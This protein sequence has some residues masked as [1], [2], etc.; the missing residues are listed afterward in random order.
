MTFVL[1]I[2]LARGGSKSIPLKNLVKVH[3]KPLLEYTFDVAKNSGVLN[4]YIVST[5]SELIADF[6]KHAGVS[7]PFIRPR[8]LAD[9]TASS[10][11]ALRHAVIEY[12]EHTGKRVTHIAELMATNPMKT[13]ADLNKM[14]TKLLVEGLPSIIAVHRIF[15]QHPC[16]LKLIDE[17]G[18]LSDFF[19]EPPEAR[20]QALLPQVFIRSGAIYAMTREFLFETSG[21][22]MS[23]ISKAYLLAEAQSINID[24]PL[25]V[26]VAEAA[27]S[28]LKDLEE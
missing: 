2:T 11:D 8:D 22:Y 15:D 16:R 28:L 9:D 13:S 3:D 23:G 10:T 4:D 20:R 21:R 5:D 19:P 17:A 26:L 1:G 18:T 6:A 25:D 14:V 27:L 12:E 7:V 24:E